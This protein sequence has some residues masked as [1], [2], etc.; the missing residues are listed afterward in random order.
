MSTAINSV[1]LSFS[2]YVSAFFASIRGLIIAKALGPT[3]YGVW[4]ALNVIITYSQFSH[5]GLLYA[6]TKEVP[7][8]RQK[9]NT[10]KTKAILENTFTFSILV[11]V[12]VS[13]VVFCFGLRALIRKE[14][15][16]G[17]SLLIVAVVCVLDQIYRFYVN[18]LRAVEEF[19]LLYKYLMIFA[20]VNFI[21][22]ACGVIFFKFQGLM[23]AF[24]VSYFFVLYYVMF[25]HKK[26]LHFNFDAGLLKELIKIGFPMM[27][28]ALNY[29]LFTTADR[30]I[31]IW[32]LD[33]RSLGFYSFASS[34]TDIAA[35]FANGI[36]F[37]YFPKII[38]EYAQREKA[39]DMQ[40][41]F[42]NITRALTLAAPV[43]LSVTFAVAMLLI[44]L[45]YKN[46]AQAV[47][48][49]LFI[50]M[51][52]YFMVVSCMAG[53]VLIAVNAIKSLL[54]VTFAVFL[55][56]VALNYSLVMLGFKINAI[57]L[58]AVITNIIYAYLTM[59]IAQK[60]M[61]LGNRSSIGSSFAYFA[62]LF[63]QVLAF[64]LLVGAGYLTMPAPFRML[65]LMF[66]YPFLAVSYFYLIKK[67]LKTS[68]FKELY[69]YFKNPTVKAPVDIV[70]AEPGIGIK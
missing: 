41:T 8:Y 1:K 5:F 13:A 34:F 45:W 21:L 6:Q 38:R 69:Q 66:S 51:S 70:C 65:F 46:Y 36:G 37:V 16:W 35:I 60:K 12:L 14:F 44:T 26:T 39:E 52:K 23:L 56:S 61:G 42:L 31:I 68:F 4:C 55:F 47:I 58:S 11:S 57:A 49:L 28:Y 25:M 62:V 10:S 3:S 64:Y 53:S 40:A 20:I 27:V 33:M 18:F 2:N 59:Y 9:G 67:V 7:F 32:F 48:P 19:S 50:L 30:L 24:F 54:K 43:I 63:L 17:S 29:L 15:L 22:M